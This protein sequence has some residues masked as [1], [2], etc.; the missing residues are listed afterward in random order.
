MQCAH[1]AG[2][3]RRCPAG[4]R[5][6]RKPAQRA[7][8]RAEDRREGA[9]LAD[10]ARTGRPVHTRRLADEAAAAPAGALGRSS[11]GPGGD[12]RPDQGGT[13][14]GDAGP[15]Q[16]GTP[17]GDA[18]PD[19]R[20]TPDGDAGPVQRGTP[21]RTSAGPPAGMPGPSSAGPPAGTP[22]PSSAGPPAGTPG[23][24][25][26][27]RQAGPA[28]DLRR[29][30]RGRSRAGL[31]S[32]SAAPASTTGLARRAGPT[33]GG[34][35]RHLSAPRAPVAAHRAGR[36][37]L[38]GP[39]L[40][41]GARG[42]EEPHHRGRVPGGRPGPA[43]CGARCRGVRRPRRPPTAAGRPGAGQRP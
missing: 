32:E 15:V 29:G 1:V 35:S 11:A 24:S 17:G 2:R 16:R 9:G 41:V 28:R 31:L 7:D 36:V 6:G 13:P 39:P 23:P 40:G 4:R 34:V 27:G 8:A 38:V 12:A 10:G 20:G 37:V 14:G 3:G 21:G 19:Q 42:E 25:S 22:G 5:R 26:A 43:V 18:G 30:C 33:P